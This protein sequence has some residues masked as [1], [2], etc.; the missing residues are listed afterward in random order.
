[1]T[2]RIVLI[3]FAA[4]VV[5]LAGNARMALFDRDE[6]RY[7][8]CSRQMLQSGDWVVPRIYDG[9][10]TQK[11][12]LI[13]WCQAAA[14]TLFGSEGN[15]GAFAAR[16]PS[17]LAMLLTL[18]LLAVVLHRH[19][20][21]EQAMWTV[22]VLA[23]SAMA[24]I[25]AK[26]CLTDS[27]LIL[28]ITVSQLCVY[29]IWRGDRSWKTIV[30]L[31]VMIGLGGLT[32]GPFIL[33]ILEM[34]AIALWIL[35]F[36]E[37]RRR[38]RDLLAQ[39]LTTV[40]PPPKPAA[41]PAS[42]LLRLA[43]TLVATLIVV[44]I[45]APWL[46]LVHHRAPE[47]LPRILAE[48]RQ[49]SLHGKEGHTFPPGYHLAM[50]WPMFMPWSLLLPLA[51]VVAFQ[52]RRLPE[53]RFALAAV[54]GPWVMVELMGT[55]LPHYFLPAYPALAYLVAF[56]IRRCL[57]GKDDELRSR[58]FLRATTLWALVAG[59]VGLLPWI[60]VRSFRPLPWSEMILLS[61]LTLGMS[62]AVAWMIFSR[63]YARAF[64]AMGLG[65]MVCVVVACTLYMPRAPFLRISNH[66]ADV[67]I[68]QGATQPGE[69]KMIDYKE[70][71]LA[72]YQGG[73]I[74]E[75]Q[76]EK[77]IFSAPLPRWPRWLVMT[78]EVWNRLPPE[79][80]PFLQVIDTF[81]GWAYADR[82]RTETVMVVRNTTR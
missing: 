15:A 29:A 81:K 58:P 39:S 45:A 82:G 56:T 31:A 77:A 69:E 8:Q 51:M 59:G 72:F 7:A 25:A 5:Y 33:G 4:A 66:V 35:N 80:K 43:Q 79:D 75:G 18:S 46:I 19:D 38:R 44:A 23:S 20:G 9:L 37:K 65:M 63:R 47:F 41:E 24:I 42:W 10:R 48:A 6:P 26:I 12:P 34:T 68:A 22:F 13:Y 78:R 30:L 27:V 3:L 11:P 16:V 21:P 17:V 62:I 73:T 52:N 1:M 67:L 60:A 64:W 74:R 71:S 55:K 76:D 49:H 36:F 32:K 2:K 61:L 28:F 53:I 14:M 40:E 70:P 57:S 50:V 54:L